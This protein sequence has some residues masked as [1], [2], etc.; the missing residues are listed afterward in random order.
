MKNIGQF[1]KQA[2]QL[3]HKMAEMQDKM[4]EMVVEGSAGGGMVKALTNGKGELKKIEIDPSLIDPQE[5][6]ILED[7]IVAAVNDACHKAE[8]LVSEEMSKLTGGLPL[9]SGFKLP[10]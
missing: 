10:F 9:P 7:L 1:M 2:Q 6:E 5:I 4:K 3:Q 8:A